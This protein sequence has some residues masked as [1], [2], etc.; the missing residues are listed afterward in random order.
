MKRQMLST[1]CRKW[2][3]HGK[4]DINSGSAF[5]RVLSPWGQAWFLLR[6][7][8][9]LTKI[10]NLSFLY[11]C[12]RWG[13]LLPP[14]DLQWV[15]AWKVL[16][17]HLLLYKCRTNTGRRYGYL[18]WWCQEIEVVIKF[19]SKLCLQKMKILYLVKS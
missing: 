3:E 18:G 16:K 14:D 1:T 13:V 12:I 6:I 15:I 7:L 19:D 5:I 9:V 2:I 10:Q 11:W 17:Q 8:A 4:V